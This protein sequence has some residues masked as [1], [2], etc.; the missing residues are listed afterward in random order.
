MKDSEFKKVCDRVGEV[1]ESRERSR[2]LDKEHESN[3]KATDKIIN[4]CFDKDIV[5][6]YHWI[7]I[8]E[9]F[10]FQVIRMLRKDRGE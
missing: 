6:V 2:I 3:K 4:E 7:G 1:L 5:D 10:C 9:A 8:K